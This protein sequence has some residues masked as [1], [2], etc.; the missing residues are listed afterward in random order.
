MRLILQISNCGG[1]VLT[2]PC[3]TEEELNA[4][5]MRFARV[6]GFMVGDKIE[7]VSEEE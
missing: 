2:K 3:D 6:E 7:I 4:E 5:I 1:P